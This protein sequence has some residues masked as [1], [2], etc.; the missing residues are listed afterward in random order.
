LVEVHPHYQWFAEGL[1]DLD[2]LDPTRVM[3]EDV[4]DHELAIRC[5]RLRDDPL[6]SI[7]RF[8]EWLFDENMTT[9]IEGGLGV[10]RMGVR[11]GGDRNRVGLRIPERLIEI[12]ELWVAAAEFGVEGGA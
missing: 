6:G 4:A 5:L 10:I 8:R 3:A 9:G 2:E 1:R 12:G 11:I 7:D